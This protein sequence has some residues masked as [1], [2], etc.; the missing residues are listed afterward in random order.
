LFVQ[1]HA[2]RTKKLRPPF[3]CHGGKYYLAQWIIAHFPKNYDR[4]TYVE[5]FAG[6][7]SVLLQKRRSRREI[8][9]DLD[10]G[11][12]G[13][14]TALRDRPEEFI[15]RLRALDYTE[16]TFTEALR[17][18]HD[19]LGDLDAAVNAFVLRRMSR[20]GLQRHF[21]WSDRLR[22]GKPGDLNAWETALDLLPAISDRLQ[23]VAIFD[24]SA[25]TAI[26]LYDGP[27]TLV[28]ADPPYLH[29]S[30]NAVRAYKHEM[31]RA[32]H[33][34]LAG[35]L[36]EC[37]SRVVLSGYPSELYAELYRGWRSVCREVAN[38]AGQGETKRRMTETLW[39]NW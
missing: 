10:V 23:G 32:D 34:A 14:L 17:R 37:R 18:Q 22:G 6:G 21:A 38:H 24:C 36:L 33:V 9:A 31:T 16:A 8:V 27:D 25:A 19:Q 4:P 29:E 12:V 35:L 11:V 3:K 30:R 5:P 26:R 13:I 2:M 28:Y 7:V 20:G 39:L 15:D 1:N